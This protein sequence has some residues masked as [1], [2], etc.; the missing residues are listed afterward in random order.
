MINDVLV[1][2]MQS[3]KKPKTAHLV[4]VQNVLLSI[5]RFP[6]FPFRTSTFCVEIVSLYITVLRMTVVSYLQGITK[7]WFWLFRNG[8]RFISS[9]IK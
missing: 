4:T 6:K 7:Y 1:L 3:I 9:A 5:P 8:V 2:A